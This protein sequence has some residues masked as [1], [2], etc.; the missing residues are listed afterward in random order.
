MTQQ[1]IMPYHKKAM[2]NVQKKK[3]GLDLAVETINQLI[4]QI[5]NNL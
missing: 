1:K 4:T 3:E 5:L 2:L